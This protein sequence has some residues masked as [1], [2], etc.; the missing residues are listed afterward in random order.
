MRFD[1]ELVSEKSHIV[2]TEACAIAKAI[3]DT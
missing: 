1:V 3:G 2:F